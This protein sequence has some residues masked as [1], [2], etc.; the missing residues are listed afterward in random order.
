MFK[1]GLL[2]L[3]SSIN[4]YAQDVIISPPPLSIDPG[5]GREMVQDNAPVGSI[6][7]AKIDPVDGQLKLGEHKA[8]EQK[9]EVKQENK[10]VIITPRPNEEF[11]LVEPTRYYPPQKYIQFS[12]GYLNS[13]YDRIDSS[14]DNGS[15]LTDFRV[16][17][18]M[19]EHNQFGFA[20]E[21]IHDTSLET[22][23]ENI[24]ALQYK[25]F[26]DY[27]HSIFADKLDWMAGLALSIGDYSIRKLAI[28]GS[29]EKVYTKLKSGTIFGVIPSAG[30]RFYLGGRNSIDISAEYHQYLSKPQSYIGGFAFVPRFS[31]AF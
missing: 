9:N 19:N 30:L 26:M 10:E 20:L 5:A 4:L 29:G 12:F 6:L 23:P 17:S 18:D 1:L 14:L 28:N 7:P 3:L 31:F 15:T 25:L 13:K 11:K 16:V 22:I 21:L 8:D 24:R 27:H 2:L